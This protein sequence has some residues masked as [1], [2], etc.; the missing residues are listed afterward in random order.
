MLKREGCYD[1]LLA[2]ITRFETGPQMMDHLIHSSGNE[3]CLGAVGELRMFHGRGIRWV[4]PLPDPLQHRT[5]Y[6]IAR[7]AASPYADEAMALARYLGGGE[8]RRMF[9][10]CGVETPA[11]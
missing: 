8:A 10:D 9:A 1:R 5:Q 7:M 3:V 4:G 11:G 2:K 6:V